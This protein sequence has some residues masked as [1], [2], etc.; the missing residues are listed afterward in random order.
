MSNGSTLFKGLGQVGIV[1]AE[2]AKM[3]AFYR[4]VLG[5]PLLFEAGGMSFLAAGATSLMI[6]A[7]TE[8][9]KFGDD[10]LLYFEPTDWG[11]AEAKLGAA[12]IAFEREAMVVQRDG[13]R[14][15]ALRPFRDPEGRR[16]YLL[17]WRPTT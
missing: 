3:V 7:A 6:G 11:V 5:F 16:L 10:V 1:T 12:G 4:D 13:A 14:E 2:P 17:G 9:P 8:P 15:H